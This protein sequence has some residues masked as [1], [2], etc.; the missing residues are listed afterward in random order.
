MDDNPCA[1]S[2]LLV[3][4]QPLGKIVVRI[5]YASVRGAAVVGESSNGCVIL[6]I[7]NGVTVRRE[8]LPTPQHL[9]HGIPSLSG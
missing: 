8:P 4:N 7:D 6:G 1:F 9:G 2:G 5:T 3:G